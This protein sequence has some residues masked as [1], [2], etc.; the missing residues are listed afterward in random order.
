[1]A[2]QTLQAKLRGLSPN[3][4]LVLVDGKRRHTTSNLAVLGGPYQGG[5]GVDL[6]FIPVAAIEHV[7]VLTDGAAAQYGTDA[8]AGVINII[9]KKA[10]RGGYLDTNFGG[11]M[12]QGGE[13]LG[14]AGNIGFEP[15]P[16]GY[17]N[18]T[19]EFRKHDHS[20]R[21]GIDPRLDT[22][23]NIDPA[24]GATYPNINLPFAAGY[25]YLNQIS[26]TRNTVCRSARSVRASHWATTARSTS[27][28]PTATSARR[29]SKTCAC[30][31]ASS[32]RVRIRM[33]RAIRFPTA[34]I[35]RNSRTRSISPRRWV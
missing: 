29:H 32:T 22:P 10:S 18:L 31:A 21:G 34:S 7:E 25:P 19:A 3:H 35:P 6:N 27:S 13:T 26:A 8:I 4:V 24:A 33:W 23:S 15:T 16:G 2:N 9:T 11:Y 12:D 28:V 30:R 17:I 1:M 14:G 5:A 20:N